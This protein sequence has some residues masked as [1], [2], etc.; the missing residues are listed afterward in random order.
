MFGVA[1]DFPK[2]QVQQIV[3]SFGGGNDSLYIDED[4]AIP[5]TIHGGSGDDKLAGGGGNDQLFGGDGNDELTGGKG[6]DELQGE[7]GDDQL[8]GDDG[9]D[10]VFGGAGIDTLNGGAGNDYVQGNA[11]MIRCSV[12]GKRCPLW[13]PRNR[14]QRAWQ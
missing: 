11:G 4:L 8:E 14:R 9:S 2:A 13:R 1:Q 10:Q 12:A 6:D 5:A 3:G 7:S